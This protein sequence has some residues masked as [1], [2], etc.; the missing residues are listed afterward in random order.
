MK[1]ELMQRLTEELEVLNYQHV[2]SFGET[3]CVLLEPGKRTPI[4]RRVVVS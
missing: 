3:C 2:P 4:E 1:S